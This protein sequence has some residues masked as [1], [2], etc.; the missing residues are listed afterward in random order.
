VGI[1]DAK[2]LLHSTIGF[3]CGWFLINWTNNIVFSCIFLTLFQAWRILKIFAFNSRMEQFI[4]FITKP[5]VIIITSLCECK[6]LGK[7]D[8]FSAIPALICILA[9]VIQRDFYNRKDSL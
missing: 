2:W 7:T 1:R 8:Y 3:S 5:L 9:F 4:I 6:S